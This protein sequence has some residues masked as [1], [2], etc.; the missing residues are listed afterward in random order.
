MKKYI[1]ILLVLLNSKMFSLENINLFDYSNKKDITKSD[2]FHIK[3][4][5]NDFEKYHSKYLKQIKDSLVNAFVRDKAIPRLYKKLDLESLD[6]I[7][8]P[9]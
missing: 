9:T 5:I 4:L 6:Y 1:L 3:R 7:I 8:V 2:S